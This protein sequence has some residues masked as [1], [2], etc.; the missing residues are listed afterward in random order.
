MEFEFKKNNPIEKL[1]EQLAKI[2]K[3]Y[4]DKIPKNIRKNK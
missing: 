3:E 4:S 2:Q 1:L